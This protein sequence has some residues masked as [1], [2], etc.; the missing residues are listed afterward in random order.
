MLRMRPAPTGSII[1][2]QREYVGYCL[3]EACLVTCDCCTMYCW[4]E[5]KKKKKREPEATR[6]ECSLWTVPLYLTVHSTVIFK[7]H[8]ALRQVNIAGSG[9]IKFVRCVARMCP[10]ETKV[11]GEGI[12]IGPNPLHPPPSLRCLLGCNSVKSEDGGSTYLRNDD[13][14]SQ[15]A[16]M[17]SNDMLALKRSVVTSAWN[18]NSEGP[19]RRPIFLGKNRLYPHLPKHI[20]S[21]TRGTKNTKE[22]TDKNIIFWNAR[23][24]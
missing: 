3:W 2:L 6:E 23:N 15:R 13:V 18:G 14:T 1:K 16:I 20:I 10:V 9:S 12:G 7:W 21:G 4:G 5:T 19:I 8:M 17:N 24:F 11:M 22:S